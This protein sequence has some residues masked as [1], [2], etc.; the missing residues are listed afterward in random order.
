MNFLARGRGYSVFLAGTEAVLV[1]RPS[2]GA[3]AHPEDESG[4]APPVRHVL[5][6]KLL[7]ANPDPPVT[8]LDPLP[9]KA[10]YFIGTDPAKWRTN[11]ATYG[12][13]RVADVYPGIDLVYYGHRRQLEYDFVVAPGADPGAI[14]F[15]VEGADGAPP[16]VDGDGDLVLATAAGE[17]RLRKPSI[18]QEVDGVRR[19]VPGGY[20]LG[21]AADAAAG[22]HEVEFRV[23]AYDTGKPLVIDPVL[24]YSTYLGGSQFDR[25]TDIAVDSQGHAYVIGGTF[26][27]DFPSPFGTPLSV[28]LG[29]TDVFVAKLHPSGSALV[30]STYLGGSD[31]EDVNSTGDGRIAVDSSHNAYVTGTTKSIDFPG[32]PPSGTATKL[33]PGGGTDVFVAKLNAT[34]DALLYSVTL[35][36]SGSENRFGG[37][38]IAVDSSHIAYV[39]GHTF[40]ADF[41]TAD[42]AFQAVKILHP[43][44]LLNDDCFVTKLDTKKAPLESL[45]YSTYLGGGGD[46][47]CSAIAIDGA[48]HAYVTGATTSAT[49]PTTD[50]AFQNGMGG[51][52]DAFVTKLNTNPTD[53]TAVEAEQITCKESLVYSTYFGGSKAENGLPNEGAIA[54]D[55]SGFI[56]VT[57]ATHS[58]ERLPLGAVLPKAG[59]S[60]AFVAKFDPDPSTP[61][62]PSSPIINCRQSLVYVTSL[63]GAGGSGIAVDNRGNAY[64]TGSTNALKVPGAGSFVAPKLG[65]G[66]FGEGSDAF[67]AKLNA[68]GDKLLYSTYLGGTGVDKGRRI[69]LDASCNAYVTGESGSKDFPLVNPLTPG[70]PKN[71]GANSDGFVTKIA[72]LG[73]R[74]YVA[75][76][77]QGGVAVI[78]THTNTVVP[79]SPLQLSPNNKFRGVAVSPD[80]RRA[81]LTDFKSS[82][83]VVMDG[84]LVLKAIPLSKNFPLVDL[85]PIGV[86]VHP[87]GKLVYVANGAIDP[88]KKTH[89]I[90]VIDTEKNEVVE[91]IELPSGQGGLPFGIAVSPPTSTIGEF[92]YVTTQLGNSIIIIGR[93][94]TKTPPK[95]FVQA[96]IPLPAGAPAGIAVHPGGRRVY[97]ANTGINSVSVFDHS[98]GVSSIDVGA[99]QFGVAAHPDESRVYV[100]LPGSNSVAVIKESVIGPPAVVGHIT[101]GNQPQGVAVTPDGALV[102]V[103][104]FGDDSVSV[105]NTANDERIFFTSAA[106]NSKHD[107]KV[108]DGPVALGQFVGFP[109]L[110][111]APSPLLGFP[112]PD[113]DGDGI[114]DQVDG[115]LVGGVFFDKRD[116][117][118]PPFTKTF[119]NRHL[120]GTV[121]GSIK[122]VPHG[123]TVFVASPAGIVI[124]TTGGGLDQKATIDACGFELLFNPDKVVNIAKCGSLTAQVLSG[125]IEIL[126]DSFGMATVPSGVTVRVA[127]LTAGEF[128]VQ[129]LGGPEPIIVE[130][131]GQVRE[132]RPGESLTVAVDTTPPTTIA[133]ASP[134]P[135]AN[136][137][138][139]GDVT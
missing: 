61:C 71:V 23:A 122:S 40:S 57:G 111:L 116:H 98:L 29:K 139:K 11:I 65:A 128:E 37:G 47:V 54:V 81:Y 15:V 4:A 89:T 34:G 112:M 130:F 51:D 7:D 13:V 76:F 107:L 79:F 115:E 118:S 105:I 31:D 135:N 101:V 97:V 91:E 52:R 77:N 88:G 41:P 62:V 20:V 58:P 50:T 18:Y 30:Y 74:A 33:G 46:D 64:V 96:T 75:S 66:D 90:S 53:C 21:E 26:S 55:P 70:G 100:T 120:C 134:A 123:M 3:A 137:W 10:N 72:E 9:G 38:G 8:G 85:L 99:P 19:P 25:G 104:N 24:F 133:A 87:N 82:T 95:H 32:P 35:G 68:G 12:R 6:M 42:K 93:D 124:G 117:P 125:P 92:I 48:G 17:L 22:G 110:N 102:Y 127:R 114:Q 16:R 83:V 129:N 59:L 14:R 1:L 27:D 78:D 28:V 80:G 119:T 94:T 2:P 69:A 56:Y 103:A 86:A 109:P 45:V 49:F 43:A 67:V 138:N 132:V 113:K 63:G 36:G 121:S 73:F 44:T 131:Q 5:R 84:T 106:A 136:G 39:T 108:G 126:L 60:V